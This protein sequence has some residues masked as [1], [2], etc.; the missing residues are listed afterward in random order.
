MKYFLLIFSFLIA[1]GCDSVKSGKVTEKNYVEAHSFTT[2]IMSGKAMIPVMHHYPE[3]W[4]IKIY[5]Q[6]QSGKYGTG[7]CSVSQHVYDSVNVGEYFDCEGA[8]Q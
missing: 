4:K 2:F 3:S 1:T 5:G 8:I 7:T 6:Y